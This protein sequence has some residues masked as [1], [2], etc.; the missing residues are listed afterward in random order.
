MVTGLAVLA[1]ALLAGWLEARLIPHARWTGW[2]LFG[3]VLFLALFRVRKALPARRAGLVSVWT[4]IH[5]W[6][7]TGSLVV[8][9]IHTGWRWPTGVHEG[10]LAAVFLL[11]GASGIA[12]LLLTRIIPVRLAAL[13]LQPVYEQIPALRHELAIRAVRTVQQCSETT[14]ARFYVNQ[15]AAFLCLP[16]S[17]SFY[18]APSARE[19]KRIVLSIRNLDRYLSE[20][21]RLASRELMQ[22][23]REKDDLD[24]QRAMQGRLKWW[25]VIHLALTGLLL[26]LAVLHVLLVHAFGGGWK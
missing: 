18:L 20:P 7:G 19:S 5:V 6:T 26:V 21:E 11:T 9:G 4:Q 24:Y 10:A 8:Y 23:V 13:S 17:W 22:I 14:L 16:R 3:T 12:G 2:I 1:V 25:L 15:V